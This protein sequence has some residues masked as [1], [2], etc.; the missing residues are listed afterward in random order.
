MAGLE[1]L[2]LLVV[3]RARPAVCPSG[4]VVIR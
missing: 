1:S 3:R 2:A 4:P